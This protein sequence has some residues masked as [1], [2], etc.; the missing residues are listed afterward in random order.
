[1][2]FFRHPEIF[3]SDVCLLIERKPTDPAPPT[4]VSMSLR[5]VIPWRVGFHQSPPPLHQP[6]II[7]KEKR[8]FK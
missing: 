4:I 6:R 7:L 8:M 5:P 3:R 1:M 2:S